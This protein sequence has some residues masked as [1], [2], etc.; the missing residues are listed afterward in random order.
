[1]RFRFT[2]ILIGLVLGSADAIRGQYLHPKVTSKQITIRHAVMLPAKVEIVR[3][4]LKGLEGMAAESEMLSTRVPQLIAE[5]LATR[6]MTVS[7]AE[8]AKE[9][10]EAR[11]TRAD[12]EARYDALLPKITKKPKDVTKA[13]FTMGDEVLNLN[14]DES[15]DVLV[16]VR[17]YGQRLTKGKSTFSLLTLSFDSPYLSLTIGLV[18]ART[19]EVLMF[20]RATSMADATGKNQGSLRSAIEK[21]LK[22]LPIVSEARP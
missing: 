22:K 9:D 5:V 8:T 20:T 7:I 1:M 6:H 10:P 16:F 19:G 21:S 11:Y 14:V 17:G 13:R 15:A 4:S 12:I 3:Q 2:L 18:D